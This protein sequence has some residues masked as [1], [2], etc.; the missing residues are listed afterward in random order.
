MDKLKFGS[1]IKEARMKKDFTQQELADLLFVDVST[2]S[3]WERGVSYPDITLVPDICRV[4]DVSEHELIE[5]SKDVEYRKMKRDAKKFLNMKK[6]A[7]WSLN[8]G[9]AIA[10]LTC[11]IVNLAVS[12]TVSW[13]FIVLTSIM[14][15]YSFCPTI[16]WLTSKH[17]NLIFI[18]STFISLCL[19]FFTCSVYTENYW[20]M[21]AITGVLLGYFTLL[22]PILFKR[23]KK[24]LSNNKYNEFSKWFLL[25]YTLMITILVSILLIAIYVYV[26][27]DLKL[28]LMITG[29]VSVVPIAFGILNLFSISNSLNKPLLIGLASLIGF[30]IVASFSRAVYLKVTESTQVY[31]IEESYSSI[32]IE[33]KTSDIN[34]YLSNNNENKIVYSVN[35]NI[36]LESRVIDGVLTVTQ[37]DNSKFYDKLFSWGDLEINLYLTQ[38]TI[39]SLSIKNSTGDIEIN[40]GFSFNNI[41]IKLTT[42]DVDVKTNVTNNLSIETSTGD[43][44]INDSSVVGDINVK[45]TTGDIEIVN[46]KA[47]KLDIGVSTGS[48]LLSNTIVTNDFNMNGTT[49]NLKL[50]SFDAQNIYVTLST[51]SVKGTLL[52]SKI[53]ITNSKTGTIRVPETTTGGIC[54]ITT[55]TGNIIISYKGSN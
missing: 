40:E 32:L 42:G 52:S 2:V 26:P 47:T 1:F 27:F 46:S 45:T 8:I 39:E 19:L 48:T 50:D 43:V 33:S 37:I 30:L 4:L 3:K 15:A 23:Q 25:S 54:K 5:S 9:Y 24:Y 34:I 13:F 22:F 49:G 10:I 16:T 6:G 18:G 35:K 14:V 41:N 55:S 36:S 29:G 38:D 51:G 21:I 53:F 28:G 7:F 20:F 12:K 17:K 31:I 11:F 44:E